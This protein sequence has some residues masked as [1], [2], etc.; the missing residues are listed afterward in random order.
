MNRW[1][2]RSVSFDKE[3]NFTKHHVK[4]DVLAGPGLTESR[5]R[6]LCTMEEYYFLIR[7]KNGIDSFVHIT[8]KTNFKN[9]IT[10]LSSKI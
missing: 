3:R 6:L 7:R 1:R 4:H 5:E 8:R 10:F 2:I 9:L